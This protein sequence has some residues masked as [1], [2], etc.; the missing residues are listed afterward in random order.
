MDDV[1]SPVIVWI[2]VDTDI[3]TIIT[4]I[5]SHVRLIPAK[6]TVEVSP[7]LGEDGG[8]LRL[9]TKDDWSNR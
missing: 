1:T 6:Y 3:T 2:P 4:I 5:R 7:A 9:R 8:P